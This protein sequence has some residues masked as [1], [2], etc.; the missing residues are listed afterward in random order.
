MFYFFLLIVRSLV[1]D[2]LIIHRY[3]YLLWNRSRKPWQCVLSRML[4]NVLHYHS[5]SH[6]P[7]LDVLWLSLVVVAKVLRAASDS[8]HCHISSF[9]A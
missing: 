2:L 7:Y 1:N 8:P 6:V 3:F 9:E 5:C 4:Q